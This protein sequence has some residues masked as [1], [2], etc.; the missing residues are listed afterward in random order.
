MTAGATRIM[1]VWTMNMFLLSS[2]LMERARVT[3][4]TNSTDF[5]VSLIYVHGRC[6]SQVSSLG[7]LTE[8][9][10][11]H[12]PPKP[13]AVSKKLIQIDYHGQTEENGENNGS[14]KGRNIVVSAFDSVLGRGLATR[15]DGGSGDQ[16]HSM[17]KSVL[18]HSGGGTHD[19]WF[20]TAQLKAVQGAKEVLFG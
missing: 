11:I 2:S 7:V 18:K 17:N 6:H 5:V 15:Q 1:T 13:S 9:R 16:I 19:C 3:Y 4:P 10:K 20:A 8:D 14:S 12:D